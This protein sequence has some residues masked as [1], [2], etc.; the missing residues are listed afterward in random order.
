MAGFT[1]LEGDRR[2]KQINWVGPLPPCQHGL[3]PSYMDPSPCTKPGEF[4]SPT[5]YG[6]WADLCAEH[7]VTHSKPGSGL[8]YHR[9]PKE[10]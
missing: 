10:N 8:G 6:P 3:L 7:A 1:V 5:I 4:D 9:I 2:Y